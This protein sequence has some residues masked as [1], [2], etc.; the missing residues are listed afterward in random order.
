MYAMGIEPHWYALQVV[1]KREDMVAGFLRSKGYEQYVPSCQADRHILG[2]GKKMVEKK[3]FPG[4]VFCRFSYEES[5]QVSKGGGVV[6]TPGVIRVLGGRKPVPVASDEI[7]AIRLALAAR[8][9]PEPWPFQIGQKVKIETGPLRGVSGIVIRSD[10]KHRL[11]L[12]VEILQRSV[13][14]TVQSDWIAPIVTTGKAL[15]S[16]RAVLVA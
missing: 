9:Y 3:L 16:A 12:S 2:S 6:T 10:G 5:C 7:E 11:V 4:Y 8:L 14:A 15:N 13:A 1:P